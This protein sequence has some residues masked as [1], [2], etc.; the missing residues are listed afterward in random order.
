MDAISS[1]LDICFTDVYIVIV[2]P[3][4]PYYFVEWDQ[5][6]VNLSLAFEKETNS[7]TSATCGAASAYLFLSLE[8]QQFLLYLGMCT[9]WYFSLGTYELFSSYYWIFTSFKQLRESLCYILF[10]TLVECLIY[11]NC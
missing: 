4:F 6:K 11:R 5:P 2:E 9:G 3:T 7:T 8:T 10:D 1:W